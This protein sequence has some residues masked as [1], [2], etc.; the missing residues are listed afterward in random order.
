VTDTTARYTRT[1]A[2]L[3]RQRAQVCLW[4]TCSHGWP[5]VYE[6]AVPAGRH[7]LAIFNPERRF[8]PKRTVVVEPGVKK[9]VSVRW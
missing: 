3:V 4:R 5:P 6:L 2:S 8:S 7:Q 1:G 9:G